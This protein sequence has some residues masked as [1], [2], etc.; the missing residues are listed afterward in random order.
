V[1]GGYVPLLLVDLFM[2][3][4]LKVPDLNDFETDIRKPEPK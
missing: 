4:E 2:D 3:V 1:V